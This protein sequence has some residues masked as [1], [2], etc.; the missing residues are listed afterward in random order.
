MRSRF[1]A[2]CLATALS[3]GLLGLAGDAR[4]DA[5][6][7]ACAG[8]Q[9]RWRLVWCDD[10]DDYLDPA[11]WAVY[12]SP[13]HAGRGRR[14]PDQLYLG[15]G[16]LFLHGRADGVTAGLAVRH[17]QTH[18]RWE[19]RIRLYPGAGSYHPV[20]LLWPT[21]G[22]GGV[23]PAT[24]SEI[25]F[26]EVIDDPRRRRAAFFFHHPG[27]TE[28]AHAELDMTTWHTYAVENTPEGV[29]GYVDGRE[30]FRSRA[31]ATT[32]MSP[33]L[34]LDWFPGRGE[35]GEAWMEVDWLRVYAPG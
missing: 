1:V 34:Q 27:G 14:S 18:G 12:D 13:G 4:A 30:W 16:T 20:A 19:A 25:D 6:A 5:R 31:H 24:G 11:A 10:F 33:C 15:D 28:Q 22:G 2:A 21:G 26:L 9:S 32:P 3:C 23:R 8:A 17:S 35:A 7:D 29:V